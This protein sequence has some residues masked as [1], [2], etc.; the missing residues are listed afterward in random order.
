MITPRLIPL[1]DPDTTPNTEGAH[2]GYYV[3]DGDIL[4]I[5]MDRTRLNLEFEDLAGGPTASTFWEAVLLKVMATNSPVRSPGTAM[6][7]VRST[8]VC[9]ART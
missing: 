8:S 2:F 1:T 6:K 9:K 7:P 4:A 5:D 3:D